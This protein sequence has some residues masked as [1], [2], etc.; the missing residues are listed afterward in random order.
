MRL[1]MS[2]FLTSARFSVL[3]PLVVLSVIFG[4]L[5]AALLANEKLH[6]IPV[7]ALVACGALVYAGA[8]ALL[9]RFGLANIG[10]LELLGLTDSLSQLPNRRAL[11][12]DVQR[13]AREGSE[14]ALAL[15]DLDGFKLVNDHYGHFV[16]DR[17][18]KTC[19][20][21]LREVCGS[22]ARIYR[23]GGDEFAILLIDPIAGNL[24]EGAC[25]RLL[26][27][28]GQPVIIDERSITVGVSIGLARSTDAEPH[29]S[30]ELL[31]RSDAAMYSSKRAGKMRCTWFSPIFDQDRDIIREIDNEL[32][33]ALE[34][35][36][37]RVFYQPLVDA[38]S[39][40]I[41][42]VEALLRWERP[43]G[44]KVGPDL[45]IPVAE[46]SGLINPIGMWVLRQACQD[47]IG[48]GD[49]TLSVN[50]SAA[51]LRNTEFPI[52]LGQMLEETGF[53]PNRLELELTE[54]F[55]VLDPEVAG[56]S[57]D[58]LREFGIRIALDDFGTGYASIGF[59]RQF[60]FEK[61]KID[62]SLVVEATTDKSSQAM[63][64]ASIALARALDMDVTAE[65]VETQAQADLV[66]VA[67]CDQ[68]QGWLYYKAMSATD[69]E[70]AFVDEAATNRPVPQKAAG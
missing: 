33:H 7:P 62:R 59:L 44:K 2:N 40:Q 45:F 35:D 56:R 64:V 12:I 31:R 24:L 69:I 17:L 36:E 21:L 1:T 46:E 43:D 6:I 8:L 19:G 13:Y 41:V 57:L 52:L 54:T 61:L 70:D 60:R 20:T 4:G 34:H 18:I 68:I 51:Q 37:F 14:T 3:A 58:V 28:F 65:G 22:D 10:R 53:P 15:L 23:L 63:M 26:E 49:I 55:L 5:L 47:A 25:R 27:R 32:R 39:C 30:S 9:A 38:T 42:A 66:R 50:V 48:W 11:L 16:G 67:G 29:N